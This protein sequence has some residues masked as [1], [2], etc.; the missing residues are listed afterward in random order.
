MKLTPRTLI[1][2]CIGASIVFI[3]VLMSNHNPPD[4]KVGAHQEATKALSIKLPLKDMVAHASGAHSPD[5]PNSNWFFKSIIVPEGMAVSKIHVSVEDAPKEII[6]HLRL[7][8]IGKADA[9]CSNTNSYSNFKEYLTV[10]RTNLHEDTIFPDG[11]MLPVSAGETLQLEVMTHILDKPYGPSEHGFHNASIMVTLE[12]KPLET[13]VDTP[14]EYIRLRLDD[15]PCAEPLAHQAFKV[16]AKSGMTTKR[17]DNG[18]SDTYVFPQAGLLLNRTA[19]VWGNKG[20]K[21]VSFLLNGNVAETFDVH[22][23]SDPWVWNID[24][25]TRPV[26]VAAG[27]TV[28]LEA[29]YENNETQDLMD[30]SGM[31]GF[32]FAKN[33][34]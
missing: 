2:I 4:S 28:T 12:Y 18:I 10:S 27:D 22:Q 16:P 5:A 23:G 24:Q 20:G 34:N 33:N 6:H 29:V 31:F 3:F 19:N 17:S 13:S 32:Y 14:L 1:L 26:S 15:T 9:M 11:Y 30:A 21:S 8:S 7:G 25:K